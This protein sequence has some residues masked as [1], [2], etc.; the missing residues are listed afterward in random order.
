MSERERS[1]AQLRPW[2]QS[3]V[4][5]APLPRTWSTETRR[6]CSYHK[7]RA[8]MDYGLLEIVRRTV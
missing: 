1:G 3:A 4:A 5:A 7:H 2:P 8:S 6:G